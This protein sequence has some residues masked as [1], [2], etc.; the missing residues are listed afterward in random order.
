MQ[1]GSKRHVAFGYD[2]GL[3]SAIALRLANDKS[4]T[5]EMLALSG[6]AC[7]P[8]YLFLSPALDKHSSPSRALQGM[9]EILAKHPEGIVAK[10]NEG[11]S[12]RCVIL[13]KDEA[14]LERAVKEIFS[15]HQ[16]L[17]IS[18]Y[19]VIEDEI[20]V[21]QLDGIALAAYSKQRDRDWRHNLDFGARPILLEPG[22]ARAASVA[23]AIEAAKAIDIRFASIDVVRVGEQWQ[24]LEINA[25]V[26]MEALGKSYPD[27]VHAIYA[28]ALDKVFG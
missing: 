8:H 18:P 10:P 6:I 24:V 7:V 26:M 27:L 22:D 20:R 1:R 15:A 25:G 17:V 13:V 23:I 21:I 4:A 16:S 19:V 2:I 5:A 3:N 11:T 28:A 14:G 12:G 9:H